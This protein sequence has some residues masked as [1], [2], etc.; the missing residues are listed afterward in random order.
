MTMTD[1]VFPAL[2][3]SG[4]AIHTVDKFPSNLGCRDDKRRDVAHVLWDSESETETQTESYEEACDWAALLASAPNLLSLLIEVEEHARLYGAVPRSAK[5]LW[6]RV[7]AAIAAA[8]GRSTPSVGNHLNKRERVAR[9]AS[10]CRDIRDV[11]R[12]WNLIDCWEVSEPFWRV[13]ADTCPW[14][15]HEPSQVN[16]VKFA[17]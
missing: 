12:L 17:Y 4:L 16:S 5:L 1:R 13:L 2:T 11:T 15:F 8:R 3:V 10:K 6:K 9:L 7:N 14:A